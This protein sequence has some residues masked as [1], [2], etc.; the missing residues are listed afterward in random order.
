MPDPGRDAVRDGNGGAG[1]GGDSSAGDDDS[2]SDDRFFKKLAR[3]PDQ[4]PAEPPPE[5]LGHF[6]ILAPIG[7][8]GMGVVYRALDE[9]LGREVALKVRPA[10]TTESRAGGGAFCARRG[11]PPR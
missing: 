1:A 4:V 7:R 11:P 8:G 6:R 9:K 2:G 5:R 3:T 10:A